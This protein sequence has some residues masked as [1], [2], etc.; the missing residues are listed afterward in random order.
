MLAFP[1]ISGIVASMKRSSACSSRKVGA[2]R[3]GDRPCTTQAR[4]V[5][6]AVP[7]SLIVALPIL[8]IYG[9][10]PIHMWYCD[11]MKRHGACSLQADEPRVPRANRSFSQEWNNPDGFGSAT[12]PVALA[13][14]SPASPTIVT[15]SPIG[16][17]PG[18]GVVFGETPKTA[19][20]PSPLR[21]DATRTTA[22]PKATESFRQVGKV[23]LVASPEKTEW[24]APANR[25]RKLLISTI[26]SV[27]F[28]ALRTRNLKT[29]HSPLCTLNFHILCPGMGL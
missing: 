7:T 5:R 4:T 6:R 28:D 24:R 27:I 10:F 17:A 1:L 15:T 13:G 25:P 9:C 19:V 23:R 11:G 3:R 16:E 8:N 14:V 22:L 21:F 12:V 20:D 2:P 29:L 26:V 18:T